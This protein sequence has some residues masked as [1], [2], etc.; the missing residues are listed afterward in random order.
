MLLVALAGPAASAAVDA[1]EFAPALRAAVQSAAVPE[2]SVSRA[3]KSAL[4]NADRTAVAVA[5]N[6]PAATLVYVFIRQPDGTLKTVDVS[7]VES[8]NFG[9]LGR[10]RTEYTR[11]ET[12]PVKWLPRDDGYLQV[13]I[14]TRA[15]A[16]RQRYTV[17]EPL[18]IS[19]NGTPVWR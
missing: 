14:R 17:S 4:W 9:K 18:V 16:G 11:F 5:I 6:R 15:W 7:G 8:G 10:S 3:I 12:M 2:T 1:A 19:V 13:V